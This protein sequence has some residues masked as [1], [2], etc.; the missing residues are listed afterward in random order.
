MTAGDIPLTAGL[1]DQ[2]FEGRFVGYS[3]YDALVGWDLSRSDVAADIKPGLATGWHIDPANNRRWIFEL[4]HGVKFH[5]GSSCTAA[6]VVWNFDRFTKESAPQ[7]NARQFTFARNP[8]GT[9][10]LPLLAH[11]AGRAPGTREE[12]RILGHR[13][14]PAS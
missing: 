13:A 4:R 1:P 7:F 14:H 11:G 12:R 10:A 6:D 8:S 9:G 3:L 5:D 2:G